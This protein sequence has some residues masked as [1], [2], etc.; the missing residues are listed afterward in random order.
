VPAVLV[1]APA[2]YGKTTLLALWAQQ[3]DRP[4]GWIT[5]DTVDN[6]PVALTTAILAAL[7]PIVPFSSAI[8]QGLRSAGPPLEEVILPSIANNCADAHRPFVLVL[9]DLHRIIEPRSHTVI[10]YLAE[11]LPPG[12]QIALA[13]R[14]DPPLPLASWRAHGQLHELR[15]AE[16][17]LSTA[18]A[19]DLL[20]AADV[21]VSHA[22]VARLVE[23]AEGWSAAIYLAALSLRN[24]AQPD[25]F[26]D[27]FAGTSRHVADF[28]S[29]DVLARLPS[30]IVDFLLY[31]C[32]LDELTASLCGAV[33]GRNDCGTL[34]RELERSNLFVVPLDAERRTYRYHHLF[35][36]YL[37][38]ELTHREPDI[39]R[40]LHG[41]AAAWYREHRLFGRAISHAQACGD[42]DAA[43]E[44]VAAQWLS[45]V[46]HGQVETMRR[47]IA[48][49]TDEEIERHAPLAIGAAWVCG[50]AGER[51]R[52]LQFAEA[53]RQGSWHGTMPDGT[54]SLE[55]ALAIMCA[56]LGLGGVSGMRAAAAR[57]VELEPLTSPWRTGALVLLG[58]AQTL[59]GDFEHARATLED[60]ARLAIGRTATG[61]TSLAYLAFIE[62]Q[63]GELETAFVHAQRAHGIVEQPGMTSHVP[64]ISTYSVLASILTR[65]GDLAGA[66]E[67]VQRVEAL[68]PRLTDAYWWQ[69]CLTR[70]LLAP[71]LVAL[72]RQSEA[73]AMLAQA[74]A[75]LATHPDAGKLHQWAQDDTPEP[76]PA[77]PDKTSPPTLT[78]A[79]R[80]VLRLL[81][82]DLTLREIGRE[83]YLSVNTVR[84][85][86]HQI[87]R[88]LGVSSRV[89][90]LRASRSTKD[91][92]HEV[93]Q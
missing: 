1:S 22:Q 32:V 10:G 63:Q 27:S 44:L 86:V 33:T 92:F 30:D 21:R 66:A 81:D 12:C 39:V 79:E 64:N 42:I 73:T 38:A 71:A 54:A 90:A 25:E 59:E 60:A 77:S 28:L 8:G 69:L 78:E 58:E 67:A 18:E 47:W 13:T 53:A 14:T 84:S 20:A 26:L 72:G 7:E 9:D 80:R 41:R 61:A 4:F 89:E 46:E 3:D 19:T 6:D 34:L 82:S 5:L 16:L 55:S 23:R 24:R 31:T 49:F 29:E 48:G 15:A 36:Q 62:L 2:G 45:M 85:H 70:I 57:A 17:A 51:D 40:E 35:S 76:R 88:K 37:R 68:L 52:A 74:R 75:L 11:H 87:Y 50:F 93:A 56:S 43:A 83:L 91:A 65:Q